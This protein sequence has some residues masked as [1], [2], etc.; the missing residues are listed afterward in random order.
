M[1]T[2]EDMYVEMERGPIYISPS[3]TD[4]ISSHSSGAIALQAIYMMHKFPSL[5]LSP[6][7]IF[8]DP[9][10]GIESVADNIKRSVLPLNLSIQLSKIASLVMLLSYII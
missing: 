8:K 3:L 4:I 2:D 1:A 7:Q 5:Y 10:Q 6:L 9:Q